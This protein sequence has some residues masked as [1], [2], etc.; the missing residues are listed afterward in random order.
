MVFCCIKM[1]LANVPNILYII[2][3]K[4]SIPIPW[5]VIGISFGEEVLKVKSLEAKFEANWNFLEGG[6][7]GV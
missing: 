4:N 7:G 2:F 5:K 3:Q 6:G 1:H